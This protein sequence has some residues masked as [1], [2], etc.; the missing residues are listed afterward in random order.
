MKKIK[1][2]TLLMA[3]SGAAIAQKSEVNGH[4]EG[5]EDV[6]IVF[7]RQVGEE[8]KQDTVQTKGGVFRWSAELQSPQ[9][10]GIMFPGRYFDFFA[11]GNE[12]VKISGTADSLWALQVS[13][14]KLQDEANAYEESIQDLTDQ[15]MSIYQKWGKVSAEEQRSLEETI[16]PLRDQ[17]RERANQYIAKHPDSYFSL[18]LVNDRATMGAYEDIVPVY[19]L[20]SPT[21]KSSP[22]GKLLTARIDV[23]KRSAIG[24]PML[25]FTQNDPEGNPVEFAEFEGKYVLVD[26]WASGCGPCR[27]ENPNVLREYN[28]YKD[29][30][31][32]VVGVSLDDNADRW[33][34]AIEEDKMPWTQVSDLQGFKNEVST[35]YG[36]MGIPSTLLV[37]PNGKIIAKDLRGQMLAKKLEELFN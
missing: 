18:N 24:E 4:I 8:Y 19:K 17:K 6:D 5:L 15:E 35:Y 12:Q 20:L 25:D 31:F 11:G 22:V 27:A 3:V 34:K 30:N 32:T 1:L 26:F 16:A 28:L 23:L 33:K 21:M 7:T 10:I 37:D 9:K 36:I 29:K 14:S 2:L 13:G